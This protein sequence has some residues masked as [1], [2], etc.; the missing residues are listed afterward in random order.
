MQA[1]VLVQSCCGVGVWNRQSHA[2]RGWIHWEALGRQV[3]AAFCRSRFHLWVLIWE[4]PAH[5]SCVCVMAMVRAVRGAGEQWEI[6]LT[7][8]VLYIILGADAIHECW[9]EST[10]GLITFCL[11]A[12]AVCGFESHRS[13]LYSICKRWKMY[14]FLAGKQ[15]W[16]S[17]SY[18]LVELKIITTPVKIK[19]KGYAGNKNIFLLLKDNFVCNIATYCDL[20]SKLFI[21]T[22]SLYLFNPI[23]IFCPN[24][25]ICH[26]YLIKSHPSES[27][28]LCRRNASAFGNGSRFLSA[29]IFEHLPHHVLRKWFLSA[30]K[31]VQSNNKWHWIGG[32][33]G[34][35]RGLSST[36]CAPTTSN[37]TNLEIIF[38]LER[39]INSEV[40]LLY[41]LRALPW[42]VRGGQC[43]SGNKADAVRVQSASYYV[44]VCVK[45]CVCKVSCVPLFIFCEPCG[46]LTGQ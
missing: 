16:V 43:L 19:P 40:L 8:P 42:T 1:F 30:A 2:L 12:V 24:S 17:S 35:G 23:A 13:S 46:S 33:S 41:W 18:Q 25:H 34:M 38:A 32:W 44:C 37:Q 15:L 6:T 14:L 3:G 27:H 11:D 39:Y 45:L 4:G 9:L 7:G 20:Y 29:S 26:I 28:R 5:S 22:S 31:G 21:P 10:G 36:D